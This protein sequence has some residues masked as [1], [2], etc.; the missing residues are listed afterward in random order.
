[1]NIWIVSR[2]ELLDLNVECD[3][4]PRIGDRIRVIGGSRVVEAVEWRV[5]WRVEQRVEQSKGV[6]RLR[7][8]VLTS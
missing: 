4:V 2:D 8:K 6:D 3:Q 7:P 1:M 5:E